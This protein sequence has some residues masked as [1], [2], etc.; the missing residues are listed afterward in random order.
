MFALSAA[1]FSLA[2][3]MGLYLVSRDPRKPVLALTA[4]GLCAFAAVVALDAVRVTGGGGDGV[5]SRIEVYMVAVPG[6][7]WLP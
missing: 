1:V 4:V 3:W 5:L 6:I 7:A 2:W